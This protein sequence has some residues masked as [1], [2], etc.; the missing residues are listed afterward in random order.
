VGYSLTSLENNLA[1]AVRASDSLSDIVNRHLFIAVKAFIANHFLCL[2]LLGFCFR[3]NLLLLLA[4]CVSLASEPLLTLF[5]LPDSHSNPPHRIMAAVRALFGGFFQG[6]NLAQPFPDFESV[7]RTQP[8]NPCCVFHLAITI[9][10][11][12]KN[13]SISTELIARLIEYGATRI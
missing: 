4:E 1:P 7:A 2:F 8:A 5:A 9:L 13:L 11:M 6:F 3:C 12:L 10:D